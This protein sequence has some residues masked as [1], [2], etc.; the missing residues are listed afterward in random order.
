MVSM[1]SPAISATLHQTQEESRFLSNVLEPAPHVD[2]PF[3][4]APP[5]KSHLT[6]QVE[7]NGE[8]PYT[9]VLDTGFSSTVLFDEKFANTLKLKKTGATI[10]LSPG[11]RKGFILE[12][13]AISFVPRSGTKGIRCEVERSACVSLSEINRYQA[14]PPISGIIGAEILERFT[15]LLDFR[16]GVM[17]LYY[18]PHVPITLKEFRSIQ[19]HGENSK[20]SVDVNPKQGKTVG[21]LIDTG[22]SSSYLPA[23]VTDS[24]DISGLVTGSSFTFA[25]NNQHLSYLIPELL[26]G[27]SLSLSNLRVLDVEMSQGEDQKAGIIGLDILSRFRVILDFRNGILSLQPLVGFDRRN[28][29]SGDSGIVLGGRKAPF[30]IKKIEPGVTTALKVGDRVD[31]IDGLR[32]DGIPLNVARILIDGYAGQVG[33]IEITRKGQPLPAIDVNRRNVYDYFFSKE[34]VEILKYNDNFV[35][36]HVRGGNEVLS[37]ELTVGDV[38]VK[39]NGSDAKKM[40][41]KEIHSAFE[42]AGNTITIRKRREETVREF[43]TSQ[44]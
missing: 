19:L 32:L 16:L 42:K 20:Y 4:Y 33:T 25:G 13:L 41:F 36:A 27:N 35:I 37:R 26:I 5:L 39:V 14:G 24:M 3:Q 30:I 7:V 40:R 29:I 2:I 31:K 21:A 28:V 43:V 23:E 18:E 34:I 1:S 9:F 6:I 11:N 10:P 22:S 8:G 12:E 17:S 15:V 38:V 44:P